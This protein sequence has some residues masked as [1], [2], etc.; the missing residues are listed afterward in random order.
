MHA[1]IAQ[2]A[3]DRVI[4]QVAI[5]AMHL[6]TAV[7]HLEAGVSGEAFR[8][9]RKP[10]RAGLTLADRAGR[11]MQQ[12]PR[13]IERGRVIGHAELQRL[14]IGE[15]RAELPTLL[16]VIDRTVEA[17]LRAAE[18]TGRNVEPPAVEPTHRDAET[19][20]FRADAVRNWHA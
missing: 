5:A 10:R 8:L 12:E 3:L 7:D 17:E 11:A 6:Q 20:A 15:P 1:Q 16:H 14:E 4:A 2:H 9:R 19:L 13:G 18:R